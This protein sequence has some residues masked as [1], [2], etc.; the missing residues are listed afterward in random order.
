MLIPKKKTLKKK[1]KKDK[2]HELQRVNHIYLEYIEKKN[3]KLLK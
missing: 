3:K 2:E 1:K